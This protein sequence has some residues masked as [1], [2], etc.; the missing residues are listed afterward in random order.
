[1]SKRLKNDYKDVASLLSGSLR[2]MTELFHIAR[3]SGPARGRAPVHEGVGDVLFA[4]KLVHSYSYSRHSL[5]RGDP[6]FPRV[7]WLKAWIPAFAG[8][9]AVGGWNWENVVDYT[10]HACL[11]HHCLTDRHI[12]RFPSSARCAD[13]FFKSGGRRHCVNVEQVFDEP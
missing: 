7:R 13:S 10:W 4:P 1:M 6:D 12:A 11:F 5:K 3:A 9:T 2:S 8:M